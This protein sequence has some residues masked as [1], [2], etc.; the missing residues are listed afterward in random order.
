MDYAENFLTDAV[1]EAALESLTA[2]GALL[3][4][5]SLILLKN[6]DIDGG[7]VVGD[8]VEADFTGYAAKTALAF[9]AAYRRSDREWVLAAPSATFIATG[10][11]ATNVV[12]GWAVVNA[13]KTALYA[14]GRFADD[15]FFMK[16]G[17][18]VQVTPELVIKF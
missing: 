6:G 4:E 8:I 11:A 3:E 10:D 13:A 9:N 1:V 2:E 5:P 15:V 14:Y 17:D 7:M 18:G 12:K 16:A